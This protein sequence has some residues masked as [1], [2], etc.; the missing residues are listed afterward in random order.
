MRLARIATDQGPRHVVAE[1][2][3]WAVVEDMFASPLVRTG[4]THPIAD[5]VLLAPVEPLVVLGMA[6]NGTP[7][8]RLIAPQAFAKSVRSVVGPGEP[9]VLDARHGEVKA[10]VEICL[11]VGRFARNLAPETAAD[12]VLGWT[13]VNDVT[14]VGQIPIDD[15]MVQVKS[16]DGY[17]PI[18]PWIETELPDAFSARLTASNSS[19]ASVDSSVANLAWNPYE[20]FEF[21]SQHLTFG[22]GDVIATGAPNTAFV[23]NP[24]DEVECTVEGIGTLVNPVVAI[25]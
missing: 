23:I 25:G 14:G 16:G 20:V 6:H 7:E 5:A 1:G 12:Y 4:E 15:K 9:I 18:G 24:G 11:V 10:E 8:D 19:G 13:V 22:P 17:T 21:L 3:V 2:E